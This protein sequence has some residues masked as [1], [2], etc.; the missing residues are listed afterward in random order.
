MFNSL[1][2]WSRL[3]LFFPNLAFFIGLCFVTS[4]WP[5]GAL[6]RRILI[7]QW[8]CKST[9][10]LLGIRVQLKGTPSQ[11]NSAS[12]IA[13]NHRSFLDP[14]ITLAHI[15]AFPLSKADVGKIPLLGF[16]AR[17]TGILF[18]NRKS[19]ESRAS[20]K[21]MMQ[22][23]LDQGHSVLL[24]PEGTTSDEEY[25]LPLKK[26]GV[27][28]TQNGYTLIP[29]LMYYHDKNDHWTDR[30]MYDQFLYTCGKWKT[31]VTLVIGEDIQGTLNTIGV[32][33]DW[34]RSHIDQ[35]RR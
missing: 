21:K 22:A 27:Q 26:G 18:V 34:Y 16:G 25:T 7:R 1:L 31:T 19:L 35:L 5:R 23:T 6:H 2:A 17:F 15:R 12:L 8:W 20:A 30:S 33:G 24:Y 13:S 9:C 3:L 32:L 14:L 28:I 10:I 11:A 4:I 29:V